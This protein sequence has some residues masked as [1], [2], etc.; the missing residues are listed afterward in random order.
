MTGAGTIYAC[1][2]K[3]NEIALYNG[4]T[5]SVYSSAQF[6]LALAALT[7]GRPYDV[8]CYASGS[9]P[10]LEFL[11]WTNDTARATA[12]TYQDGVLVKTGDATRRYLGTFYTTGVATTEDSVANRYLWN[13]YHRVQRPMKAVDT[14]NSWTYSLAAFRQANANTAN[15]L[16]FVIGVSEDRVSATVLHAAKNTATAVSLRTAVGL[17]STTAKAADCITVFAATYLANNETP[18]SAAY[19]GYPGIGKHYLAW[20]ESSGASGTTT[21]NGDDGGVL[22]QT[23]IVGE[24]LA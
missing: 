10:T 24:V 19:C 12:L 13:Y 18:L 1:P 4:T 6:S 21:W 8:F 14:T 5:W 3:G 15:Q 20:L 7:S 9:T 2:Y 23:G 16:N 22:S 11:A 17:D